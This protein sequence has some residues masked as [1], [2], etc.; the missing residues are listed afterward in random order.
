M[1]SRIRIRCGKPRAGNGL[2]EMNTYSKESFKKRCRKLW[3]RWIRS[4]IL[5]EDSEKSYFFHSINLAQPVTYH[6]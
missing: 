2:F 5:T 6:M 4:R 3:R 1:H